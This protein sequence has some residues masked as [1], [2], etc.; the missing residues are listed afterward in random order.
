MI[1]VFLVVAFIYVV[2]VIL[3]IWTVITKDEKDAFPF[4]F[5]P[6]FVWI[7]YWDELPRMKLNQEANNVGKRS[8]KKKG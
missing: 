1:A 5:L 4:C 3:N 7:L 2:G 8:K 6:Y